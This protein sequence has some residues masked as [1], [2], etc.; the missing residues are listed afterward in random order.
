LRA[1]VSRPELEIGS[2]QAQT[3]VLRI[4]G[5]AAPV[6]Q[7]VFTLDAH[8]CLRGG[9]AHDLDIAELSNPAIEGG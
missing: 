3:F 1:G 2:G 6:E 5:Q 8:D 7:D 9:P 4:R